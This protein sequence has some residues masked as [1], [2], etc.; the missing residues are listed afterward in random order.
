MKDLSIESGD[1]LFLSHLLEKVQQI[2]TSS[3]TM[4]SSLVH[5]YSFV[6]PFTQ[7]VP[8]GDP[9]TFKSPNRTS[10]IDQLPYSLNWSPK[11][12]YGN[13]AVNCSAYTSMLKYIKDVANYK[14]R[15]RTISSYDRSA[16]CQSQC[17]FVIVPRLDLRN[18]VS[19]RYYSPRIPCTFS[20]DSAV[21]NITASL[22]V[23]QLRIDPAYNKYFSAASASSE[24]VA[25]KSLSH[26][27]TKA[28][29]TTATRLRP[30]NPN[31]CAPVSVP[32]SDDANLDVRE[33]DNPGVSTFVTPH[34][35][36]QLCLD[37][38]IDGSSKRTVLTCESDSENSNNSDKINRDRQCH[39][40]PKN[41]FTEQAGSNVS[42]ARALMEWFAYALQREM[43]QRRGIDTFEYCYCQ[44]TLLPL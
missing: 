33:D 3:Q 41:T 20:T 9:N 26:S 5:R 25:R 2:T 28:H 12:S 32:A 42:A 7:Y 18:L 17:Q 19:N 24:Y 40:F 23:V 13:I 8:L 34:T 4:K 43:R 10:T 11:N 38:C 22:S 37:E 36:P 39:S 16:L 44:K 35:H 27:A 30:L 29:S 21:E 6:K 31:D 1:T 14:Q 15:I